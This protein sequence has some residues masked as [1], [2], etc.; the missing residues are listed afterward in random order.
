MAHISRNGRREKPSALSRGILPGFQSLYV[1]DE[2][3]YQFGADVPV[4]MRALAFLPV[5]LIPVNPVFGSILA[6]LLF[7]M[8][9][10]VIKNPEM[11]PA[12]R[13][14]LPI[15]NT[16]AATLALLLLMGMLG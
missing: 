12:L 10:M 13:V 2:K 9:I 1:E 6:V 5:V 3:I 11:P 8:N 14:A 4:W 15:I 7:F 16:A